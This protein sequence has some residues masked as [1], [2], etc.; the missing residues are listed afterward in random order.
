MA[1]AV[2]SRAATRA[3]DSTDRQYGSLANVARRAKPC[4]MDISDKRS[5]IEASRSSLRERR[6]VDAG[7]V[8]S[9][10]QG[11]PA[12]VLRRS[13]GGMS[14]SAMSMDFMMRPSAPGTH[15]SGRRDA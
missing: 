14:P 8:G 3:G 7:Q 13:C 2:V 9:D 10:I 15:Q 6:G 5:E 1:P 11:S 4:P 12:E